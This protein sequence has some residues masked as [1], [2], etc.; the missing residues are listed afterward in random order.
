MKPQAP[1]RDAQILRGKAVAP[2]PRHTDHQHPAIREQ[3]GRM[4]GA[5][6][7]HRCRRHPSI[8]RRVGDFDRGQR[9]FPGVEAVETARD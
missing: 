5:G 7:R 4:P 1:E 8:P 2:G 3:G 6:H 9:S